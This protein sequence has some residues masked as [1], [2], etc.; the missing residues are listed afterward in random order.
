[1]KKILLIG[2]LCFLTICGNAQ[3]VIDLEA[4]SAFAD[5]VSDAE[6]KNDKVLLQQLRAQHEDYVWKNLKSKADK[7]DVE[8]AAFAACVMNNLLESKTFGYKFGDGLSYK[9]A[10]KM[11]KYFATAID[12]AGKQGKN[13]GQVSLYRAGFRYSNLHNSY[14]IWDVSEKELLAMIGRDVQES[15]YDRYKPGEYMYARILA[16]KEPWRFHEYLYNK[17]AIHEYFE[18]QDYKGD[19]KLREE[20][21]FKDAVKYYTR[22]ATHGTPAMQVELAQYLLQSVVQ[23]KNCGDVRSTY[24]DRHQYVYHDSS[25]EWDPSDV[26][27]Y[28]HQAAY[29]YKQAAL[30]GDTIGMVN[31]A[32][33]LMA[34]IED[35]SMFANEKG[36]I[37]AQAL[38]DTAVAWLEKAAEKGSLMAMYDLCALSMPDGYSCSTYTQRDNNR[39]FKYAKM[40]AEKGS[41]ECAQALGYCYHFGYGTPVNMTEAYR[42]YKVAA[43]QGMYWSAWQTGNYYESKELGNDM[44]LAIAYWEEAMYIKEAYGKLANCYGKGIGVVMDRAKARRYQEWYDGS[45]QMKRLKYPITMYS[46]KMAE[47]MKY[48]TRFIHRMTLPYEVT[49]WR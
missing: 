12:N 42:W 7:G 36:T 6:E 8:A 11:E 34:E 19:Y 20:G 32:F 16:V 24:T 48:V 28:M 30:Q 29:W 47:G 3:Q 13:S 39:F 49:K 17:W 26:D 27:V 22:A 35:W 1:M 33:C 41:R 15:A 37:D 31:Y 23:I 5:S 14:E 21:Y 18:Y 46:V 38:G 44:E 9:D 45:D 10:R 43:D 2:M 25:D 4:F 40:G